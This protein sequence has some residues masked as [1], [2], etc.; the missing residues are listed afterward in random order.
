MSKRNG[1]RIRIRQFRPDDAEGTAAVMEAAFRSFLKGKACEHIFESFTP[2]RY[3]SSSTYRTKNPTSV[4]YIA[5]V[6]GKIMG[7]VS[8][9]ISPC[10]FGTLSV[11][12]VSPSCFHRGIGSRLMK[13]MVAFWR[14]NKMRKASTCVS[15]HTPEPSDPISSTGSFRS[16]TGETIQCFSRAP[17]VGCLAPIAVRNWRQRQENGCASQSRR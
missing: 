1:V 12:G 3:R 2:E 17:G 15:A 14:K 8:G 11:I 5:E 13:K 7:Y 6:D 10:G 4:S 16:A 9:T